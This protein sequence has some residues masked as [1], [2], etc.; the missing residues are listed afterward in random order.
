MIAA[1]GSVHRSIRRQCWIA[2]RSVCI[3]AGEIN[4]GAGSRDRSQTETD[5]CGAY[6][7][8]SG[9][10]TCNRRNHRQHI[11]RV[12][13]QF[14]R[15][16]CRHE[17]VGVA[18]S[19]FTKINRYC[20]RTVGYSIC[21]HAS[22][23]V[24]GKSDGAAGI[25]FNEFRDSRAYADGSGCTLCKAGQSGEQQAQSQQCGFRDS[26]RHCF[27]RGEKHV[28]RPKQMLAAGAMHAGG[29]VAC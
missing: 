12:T 14:E 17:V 29:K 18:W 16:L 5:V 27:L 25:N 8:G 20:K 3:G 28:Y 13:S 10:R 19:K 1:G 9:S 26:E 11:V 7:V 22:T 4:A 23:G 6:A 21:C 24:A 15:Y 2:G